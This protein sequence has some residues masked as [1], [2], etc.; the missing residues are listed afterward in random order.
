MVPQLLQGARDLQEW[1]LLVEYLA[2]QE[3]LEIFP[4]TWKDAARLYFD[5]R[6]R[7]K[8]VLSPCIAM[9]GNTTKL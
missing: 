3:Y 9:T 1:S 4:D 8:T 6:R 7:G 5:L 2:D